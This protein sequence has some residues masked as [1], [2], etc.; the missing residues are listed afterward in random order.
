MWWFRCI[1]QDDWTEPRKKRKKKNVNVK[2]QEGIHF[3]QHKVRI[4][5]HWTARKSTKRELNCSDTT[6]PT[7]KKNGKKRERP[8]KLHNT[9]RL[10]LTFSSSPDKRDTTRVSGVAAARRDLGSWP[11]PLQR[12][13]KQKRTQRYNMRNPWTERRQT[14]WTRGR[15][16]CL[17][18]DASQKKKK[19]KRNSWSEAVAVDNASMLRG[20]VETLQPKPSVRSSDKFNHHC[21]LVALVPSESPLFFFYH[22]WVSHVQLPNRLPPSPSPPLCYLKLQNHTSHTASN[23]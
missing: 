1:F 9:L 21:Q 5:W 22:V 13:L 7:K 8:N 20:L 18:S 12:R 4:N 2:F 15:M 14:D 3:I 16:M 17:S 6:T 23:R 19:L 10:R 11:R